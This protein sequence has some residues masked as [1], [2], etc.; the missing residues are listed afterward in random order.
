MYIQSVTYTPSGTRHY[1]LCWARQ[2]SRGCWNGQKWRG[3]LMFWVALLTRVYRHYTS[4][5]MA[6]IMQTLRYTYILSVKQRRPS[7]TGISSRLNW[8]ALFNNS[9]DKRIH[10]WSPS[11]DITHST[12]QHAQRT[13][14]GPSLCAAPKPRTRTDTHIPWAHN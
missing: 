14:F 8:L 10:N 7:R 11:S 9:L 1:S 6:N 3:P 4:I 13:S 12:T 2:R 5:Y